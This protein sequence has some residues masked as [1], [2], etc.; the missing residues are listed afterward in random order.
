MRE[1]TEKEIQEI[2]EE[3]ERDEDEHG[4]GY[5]SVCLVRPAA[6]GV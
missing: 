1:Y 4:C 3:Y 6:E 5:W 2:R